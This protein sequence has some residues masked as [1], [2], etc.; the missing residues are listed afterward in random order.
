[1]HNIWHATLVVACSDN[2]KIEIDL[3]LSFLKFMNQM[4]TSI[5]ST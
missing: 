1:M 3:E 2:W 5:T 4:L